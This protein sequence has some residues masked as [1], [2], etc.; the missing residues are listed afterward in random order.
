[1]L[2]YPPLCRPIVSNT[3][4][5]FK[6]S[7]GIG[8]LDEIQQFYRERSQIEKEYGGKLNA[9]ARKYHEKKAKRTGSLSVGETPTLTPGSLERYARLS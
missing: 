3:L 2:G 7:S 8:W 4:T 9:L 5:C 1:M 6:V